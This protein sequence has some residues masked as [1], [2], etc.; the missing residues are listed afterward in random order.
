VSDDL[1]DPVRRNEF[2]RGATELAESDPLVGHE[3][4]GRYT[5][6]RKL[7]H[8][9][10]GTVYLA[11]HKALDKPVALKVLHGELARKK[12]LV[13]RFMQEARVVS[14][15]RHE[16]VIDISDFGSTP[17]GH[18]FFAMELLD[19]HD[20]HDD[21]KRARN[22]GGVIPWERAK[23]IFLQVCAALAAAHKLGIVHRD[24]K[25][26]NVYLISR[27]GDRDF[28]KLLDFGIAKQTAVSGDGDRKLTRTGMLFGTPEY[29]SPEQ[30]R[31]EK[32]DHRVD[33][34]AMGCILYQLVTGH[35]PFE[36][37]NFMAVINRHM[38][39]LAPPIEPEVFDQ[40]GSPR[41]LADVI[42]TA[43]EKDR[44][45]RYQSMDEFADAVR[46]AAGEAKR[47]PTPVPA[48]RPISTPRRTTPAELAM[49]PT[50][51]PDSVIG[52]PPPPPLPRRSRIPMILG[53]G[54][55]FGAGVISA[56]LLI[57]PGEP[58]YVFETRTAPLV[59]PTPPRV[60]PR[61]K[62]P[63]P[64]PPPAPAPPEPKLPD[65]VVIRLDST[66]HGAKITD[67]SS[68]AVLG[69][70][71]LSFR[72]A[73]S[74]SPRQFSLSLHGY[75]DAVIELVPNREHIEYTE[76][77][78]KG[79]VAETHHR[80]PDAPKPAPPTAA[81]SGSAAEAGSGSAEP[82]AVEDKKDDKK[83]DEGSDQ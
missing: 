39:E 27:G 20:L 41:A 1:R 47:I 23:A 6:M 21:I 80:V 67:L 50:A 46:T 75:G 45:R 70:T 22:E 78:E 79:A 25:P 36:G 53:G 24:L 11:S 14:R 2:A 71:P 74:T 58:V 83:D 17:D 57:K 31:G 66:P 52:L 68:H 34:Y 3:I 64:P 43:L 4:A 32:I 13:D 40:G 12:E 42:A 15:I 9:G 81:G 49:L 63:P 54:V 35:V 18:V 51:A 28:V 56:I 26:E 5:V 73:G 33:V 60:E 8:G 19:G 82:P 30:G 38:T 10:M 77:L 61:P 44:D 37:D 7:G 16:H 65:S 72:L 55:L 59:A 62:P 76:T 69:K 29:M 48:T